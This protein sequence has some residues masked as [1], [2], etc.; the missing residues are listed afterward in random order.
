MNQLVGV[1]EGEEI[2]TAGT[3]DAPLFMLADVCKV[4]GLSNP[5]KVATRIRDKFKSNILLGSG[6]PPVF[7][8]EPGLYQVIMRAD[9]N[10]IAE[11]FQDWVYEDVLPSIR[12]SG[13]YDSAESQSLISEN[14]AEIRRLKKELVTK[15]ELI[16]KYRD[17]SIRKNS[18]SVSDIALALDVSSQTVNKALVDLGVQVK[19]ENCYIIKKEFEE[20]LKQY[21]A[22]YYSKNNFSQLRWTE[23]GRSFVISVIN[24]GLSS[25]D[26]YNLKLHNRNVI[27]GLS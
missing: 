17:L 4:L 23:Q 9:K 10:P 19:G 21:Y 6:S 7:V 27:R 18:Y 1:F 3:P 24:R 22:F 25:Y 26:V 11:R 20:L 8:S 12:E 2:R 15:D 13:K 5:S 14:Y 16:K